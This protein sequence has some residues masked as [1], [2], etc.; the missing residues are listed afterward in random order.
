MTINSKVP[1]HM[2][3]KNWT[4]YELG[5]R[6]EFSYDT[7]SRIA[8]GGTNLSLRTVERLCVVFG[9]NK[10]GDLFELED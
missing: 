9:V 5:K 4:A 10:I 8:K 3:I 2:N 1:L 7:A 6:G